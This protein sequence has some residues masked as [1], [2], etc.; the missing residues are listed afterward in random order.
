MDLPILTFSGLLQQMAAGLQGAAQQLIDLSVGSV[1]RA[2]L[3]ACASVILW[4]QWLILQVLAT[5][6]AATSSGSDLDSWMADF[7][8]HRLP[9]AE[10]SGVLT[11]SRYSLGMTAIIAVGTVVATADGT[12]QFTVTADDTNPAWNGEGGY[13]VAPQVASVSIPAQ[14][15]TVGTSGNVQDGTVTLLTSPIPGIDTVTN[16]AAFSG[17]QDAESD[18]AFRLRFQ[19][20]INSLSLSTETAVLN[21]IASVQL[22]LRMVVT[23]NVNT[24]FTYTPGSFLVTVDDGTGMPSAALLSSVQ[25]SVDAVRPIGSIFAVQGPSI[26]YAAVVMSLETSNPITHAAV[27]ARVQAAV[28]AWIQTL[29]ISGTLAISKLDAIAHDTDS[30]VISVLSTLI[31]NAATDLTAAANGVIL[32]TSVTVS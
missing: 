27:T 2:L 10:A 7:S 26:F 1:L 31:N 15:T 12:T 32:A 19:L 22:G 29:P 9:G 4:L 25:A 21:A 28:L 3:E 24:Q 11:F 16:S 14:C 17:G 20:Y 30:S 13:T 23:E 5:T 8:F 18:A 6:R